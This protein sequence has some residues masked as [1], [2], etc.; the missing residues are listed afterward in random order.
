LGVAVSEIKFLDELPKDGIGFYH[1]ETWGGGQIPG[2]PHDLPKRFRWTGMRA[3]MRVKSGLKNG[4]TLFLLSS[5]PDINKSPV[6][7]EIIGDNGI[8]REEVFVDNKWTKVLLKD[9][10][11][12]D[13]KVLTFQVSRTWNPKL[14]GVS[15]DSRELG[16]AVA[17]PEE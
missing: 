3:S 5:H 2:W 12:R 10:E 6:R 11:L 1:R 13:L 8:I 7:V 14:V 4:I 9:D 16:V 15:N 17:I